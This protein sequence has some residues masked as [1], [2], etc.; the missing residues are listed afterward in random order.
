MEKERTAVERQCKWARSQQLQSYCSH[1]HFC[2]WLS[3]NIH[4]HLNAFTMQGSLAVPFWVGVEAALAAFS[5]SA[6]TG[7]LSRS[8]CTF[9]CG[10]CSRCASC[11]QGSSNLYAAVVTVEG[12]I[13]RK[14]HL[15]ILLG[16][17]ATRLFMPGLHPFFHAFERAQRVANCQP[18]GNYVFHPPKAAHGWP[19]LLDFFDT[20]TT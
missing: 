18:C 15:H 11:V 9:R 3:S 12:K 5:S 2:P 19:V 14:S 8:L 20:P 17:L 10:S 16:F 1:H 7:I 13:T 6:R 4:D